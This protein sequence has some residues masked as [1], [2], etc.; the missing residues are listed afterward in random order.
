MLGL[1]TLPKG[2]NQINDW[3][4]AAK[5]KD[6]TTLE[7]FYTDNAVLCATEGVIPGKSYISGDFQQQFKYGWSLTGI[8]NQSINQGSDNDW[9]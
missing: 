3:Q 4:T 6:A 8:S 2:E 5:N 1:L 7:N 9:A